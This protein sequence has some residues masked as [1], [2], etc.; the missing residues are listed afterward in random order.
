MQVIA[1]VCAAE[2]VGRGRGLSKRHQLSVVYSWS[3]NRVLG[4]ASA[5]GPSPSGSSKRRALAEARTAAQAAE[6]LVEAADDSTARA[7]YRELSREPRAA[8]IAR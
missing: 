5:H 8:R 4:T 3:A 1:R 2:R 6:L 7:V